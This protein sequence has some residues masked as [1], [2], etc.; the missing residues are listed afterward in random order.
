MLGREMLGGTD[1]YEIFTGQVHAPNGS[2]V[3]ANIS[4]NKVRSQMKRCNYSCCIPVCVQA[5]A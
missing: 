3:W 4:S 1:A 2:V 5:E